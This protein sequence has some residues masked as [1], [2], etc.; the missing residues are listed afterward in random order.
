METILVAVMMRAAPA[1]G[2]RPEFDTFLFASIGEDG[3]GMQ[4]SVLSGLARSN[5]DPWQEAAKLAELPGK[6]AVERLTS[7][8]ETLPGKAW[9]RP[10]ARAVATRLIAL[11]PRTLAG[12]VAA[13]QT[14]NS[15]G[16][17][18][19]SRSWWVYVLLMVLVFGSQILIASQQ[20]S[21]AAHQADVNVGDEV[22]PP[23][24]PVQSGQ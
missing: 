14:P 6:T 21:P 23:Q 22:A 10:D 7:L 18:I 3:N 16:A 4:L 1:C 19:R 8:I 9:A 13:G 5:L 15:L 24:P 17:M 11:L 20:P 2:L 12:N